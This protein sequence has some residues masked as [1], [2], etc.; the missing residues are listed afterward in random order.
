MI[1]LG[2][3]SLQGI[4]AL[5]RPAVVDTPVEKPIFHPNKIFSTEQLQSGA[6]Q[7]LDENWQLTAESLPTARAK[8]KIATLPQT[9]DSPLPTM[10]T[11]SRDLLR[12]LQAQGKRSSEKNFWR[13]SLRQQGFQIEAYTLQQ[14]ADQLVCVRWLIPLEP[15]KSWLIEQQPAEPRSAVSQTTTPQSTVDVI[16]DGIPHQL[17]AQRA[18]ASG[19]TYCQLL[20]ADV[21]LGD[22]LHQLRKNSWTAEAPGQETGSEFVTIYLSREATAYWMIATPVA[23]SQSLRILLL[24]DQSEVSS[25]ANRPSST[26][27]SP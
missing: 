9:V 11:E 8:T 18:D 23:K 16:P 6:W 2:V 12:L 1:W 19:Q 22:L 15:G 5:V 17:L 24:R 25:Q 20:L 14:P 21:S 26:E 10:T 13:Y 4:S 7:F 3:W 27:D